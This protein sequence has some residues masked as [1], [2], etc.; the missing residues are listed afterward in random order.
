MGALIHYNTNDT[1]VSKETS[2]FFFS[3]CLLMKLKPK[4]KSSLYP[5]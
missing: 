2:E 4:L 3:G 5:Q 1:K